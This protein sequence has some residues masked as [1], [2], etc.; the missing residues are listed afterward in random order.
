MI[1][2]AA[3]RVHNVGICNDFRH[4][5][6]VVKRGAHRIPVARV[7]GLRDHGNLIDEATYAIPDN[8]A[9]NIVGGFVDGRGYCLDKLGNPVVPVVCHHRGLGHNRFNPEVH[10]ICEEIGSQTQLLAGNELV[11][12]ATRITIKPLH[13]PDAGAFPEGR[14]RCATRR[15][16]GYTVDWRSAIHI[17]VSRRCGCWCANWH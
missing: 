11:Q 9:D 6:A 3:V 8:I 15:E 2:T 12:I 17:P 14:I 1:R 4:N 5:L 7:N 10:D 13:L 16:F